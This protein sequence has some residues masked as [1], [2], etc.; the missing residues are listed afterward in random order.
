MDFSTNNFHAVKKFKLSAA[1]PE[2]KLSRDDVIAACHEKIPHV[3]I[4]P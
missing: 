2:K 4:S 1:E 3:F